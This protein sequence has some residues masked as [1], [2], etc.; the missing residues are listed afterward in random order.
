MSV[1]P[2]ERRN[3]DR[4]FASLREHVDR[5]LSEQDSVLGHQGTLLK[6][7]DLKL[8]GHITFAKERFE[9]VE[10]VVEAMEGMKTG[11]KVIGWVGSKATAIGAAVV[12]IVGAFF[13]IK[14]HWK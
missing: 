2:Q 11:I 8:D 14:D 7:I 9:K 4:E 3:T 6:G 5:R 10:P 1:P 13:T 12:A